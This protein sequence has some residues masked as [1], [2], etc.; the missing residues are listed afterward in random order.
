MDGYGLLIHQ[1]EDEFLVVGRGI[2]IRFSVSDA[3]IEID[4]AQEGRFDQGRW[5]R[6]RILNGD[7]R[8]FLFPNDELRTVRLKLLRR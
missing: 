2:S 6:D 7:E 3:S 4:W 8:F 1:D 5:I